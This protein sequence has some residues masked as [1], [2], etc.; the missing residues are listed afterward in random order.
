[1]KTCGDKK[2]AI[3]QTCCCRTAAHKVFP[4]WKHSVTAKND[5]RLAQAFG[6]AKPQKPN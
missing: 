2:P 6:N 4:H 3:S 1:M 5:L